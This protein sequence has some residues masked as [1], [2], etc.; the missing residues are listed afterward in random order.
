LQVPFSATTRDLVLDKLSDMN[1][2]QELCDEMYNLFKVRSTFLTTRTV[3]LKRYSVN[4]VFF[5]DLQQDKGFDRHMFEKQM[6]V[7]RGQILNL[8]QVSYFSSSHIGSYCLLV[9]LNRDIASYC[10][11]VLS[12][13]EP[14]PQE[15]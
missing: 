6:S 14:E 12:V 11:D 1:F 3:F 7:M 2:V 8:S 10:N 13:V 9:L 15:P 4:A 5:L